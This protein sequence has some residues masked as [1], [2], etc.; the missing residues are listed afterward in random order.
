MPCYFVVLQHLCLS[1]R[2]SEPKKV[3]N[4]L[5][6]M[7]RT[8]SPYWLFFKIVSGAQSFT[9]FK[10]YL[11]QDTIGGFSLIKWLNFVFVSDEGSSVKEV[12][13]WALNIALFCLFFWHIVLKAIEK[14]AGPLL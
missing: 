9:S 12:N 7:S 3:T 14:R 11:C 5:S 4:Y 1:V 10:G 8:F 6:E 2:H 13:D